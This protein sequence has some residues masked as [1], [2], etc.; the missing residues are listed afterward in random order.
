MLYE[1]PELG[2]DEQRVAD[3]IDDLKAKLKLQLHE[4]R[5]WSGSLRRLTLA[6]NIQGSNSIEGFTAALDDAAAIALGEEPMDAS[7]E[8][9]HALAGYRDAMTYVLQLAADQDFE[10]STQLLK[11][12]HFMMAHYS[13]AN[14]PGRWR[15]GAIYVHDEESGEIVHEGADIDEV[16]DLM[17]ALADGLNR[18]ESSPV[19]AAGMAHLN[20][21]MIH[22][23]RD[24]NGRMARCLQSLVLARGGVLSPVF[25]SIEE[26]LGKN[27]AEYYRVLGEVGGGSWQPERSARPWIRFVLKAHLRQAGTVRQRV[28]D[29][30]LLWSKLTTLVSA[31]DR[32][33]MALFDAAMGMRIRRS[34]YI[35]MVSDLG[36]QIS[37][38]TASR[39]LK[40]LCDAGWLEPRG[41]RRGRHYVAG[42]PVVELRRSVVKARSPREDRDPFEPPV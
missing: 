5:R 23:F 31:D 3:Q 4:P 21:V 22:P 15:Q 11:S 34:T 1:A 9:G 41:E 33:I 16:N 42:A 36:E 8:T 20:L 10:Y 12:L 17:R 2:P 18:H 26:Y 14:R 25:M 13:L 39:D 27:T 7:V 29:A 24:G 32:A 37:D 38:Q 28:R 6:R 30:E 40:A 19:V 35:A